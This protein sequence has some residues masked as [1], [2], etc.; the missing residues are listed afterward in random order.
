LSV[1]VVLKD[2]YFLWISYF[3]H[4]PNIHKYSIGENIS[5]LFVEAMEMTVY[6]SFLSK[7]EKLPYIKVAIR[8]VDTIKI[9]V[10]TAWEMKVIDDRKYIALSEKLNK[11]GQQLGGWHNK[12]IKENSPDK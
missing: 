7:E 10:Q 9:F 4:I 3:T 11:T 1:I 5:K 12:M 6:A 2:A 8:K